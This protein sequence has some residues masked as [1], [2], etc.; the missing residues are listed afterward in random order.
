MRINEDIWN[1]HFLQTSRL[2][3]TIKPVVER[4]VLRAS[5]PTL[6]QLARQF[7]QQELVFTPVAQAAKPEQLSDHYEPRIYLKKEIQTRT[8]NWH[9][10]F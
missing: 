1:P 6:S 7:R 5:W 2:F 10:F 3:D 4:H 9:D 8:E